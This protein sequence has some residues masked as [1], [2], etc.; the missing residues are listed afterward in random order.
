MSH[1]IGRR[2]HALLRRADRA[3]RAGSRIM[4][5]RLTIGWPTRLAPLTSGRAHS[6]P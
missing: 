2:R 5:M 6:V 4:S 1:G 3:P